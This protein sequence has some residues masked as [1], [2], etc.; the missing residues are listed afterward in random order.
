MEFSGD[1]MEKLTQQKVRQLVVKIKSGESND[2][3]RAEWVEKY[4]FPLETQKFTKPL[5]FQEK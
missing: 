3:E 2:K 1:T 5:C 4:I